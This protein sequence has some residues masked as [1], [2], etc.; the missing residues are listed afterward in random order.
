ML[1]PPA[2]SPSSA[3]RP[4]MTVPEAVE[5]IPEPGNP[6][7]DIEVIRDAVLYGLAVVFRAPRGNP[8]EVSRRRRVWL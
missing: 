5:V 3:S 7:V 1:P 4:P 2:F 8:G 6:E